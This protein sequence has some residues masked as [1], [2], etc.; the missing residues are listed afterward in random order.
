MYYEI[1]NNLRCHPICSNTY[2]YIDRWTDREVDG[3]FKHMRWL[4]HGKELY[5]YSQKDSIQINIT[6]PVPYAQQLCRLAQCEPDGEITYTI[7]R[8]HLVG[9]GIRKKGLF[10]LHL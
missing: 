6:T 9:E 4:G 2:I 3:Y 5:L 7:G 10:F 8:F 1:I